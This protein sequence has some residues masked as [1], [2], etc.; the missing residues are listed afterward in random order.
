MRDPD[1]L[2]PYI[3]LESCRRRGFHAL[4]DFGFRQGP[5]SLRF[6]LILPAGVFFFIH[7]RCLF[8]DLFLVKEWLRPNLL[9][10]LKIMARENSPMQV[11]K[12][13][14]GNEPGLP[15]MSAVLI[16]HG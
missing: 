6:V 7:L 5:E 11:Q 14:L 8:V 9:L 13:I 4:G 12:F 10:G 15:R 2:P 3:A 1:V 16:T